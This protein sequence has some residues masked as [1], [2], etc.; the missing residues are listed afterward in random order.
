MQTAQQ[1]L[2]AH[3]SQFVRERGVA[4]VCQAMANVCAAH[5]T[6]AATTTNARYWAVAAEQ[7]KQASTTI[8]YFA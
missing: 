2:E 7:L 6:Q 4:N 1:Q 8:R 5:A 3:L